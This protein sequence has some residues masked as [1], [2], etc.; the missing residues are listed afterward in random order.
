LTAGGQ[1]DAAAV[2]EFGTDNLSGQFVGANRFET[3]TMI[4][5]GVYT[6]TSG[7][8]I[9]D[10]V[11]LVTGTNFPDALAASAYLA[12]FGEPLLLTAT[13]L[14]TPTAAFLTD[15][16]GEGAFLEAFGGTGAISQSVLDAAES[17]FRP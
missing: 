13:S 11:G 5:E 6:D 2:A 1:A 3:A 15:H 4:A 8:L 16:A 7:E 14:T 9:G 10:G 17:A 12:W